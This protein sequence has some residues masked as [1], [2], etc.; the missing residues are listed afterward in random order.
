MQRFR[1]YRDNL[2]I[3]SYQFAHLF[4]HDT[5]LA[6]ELHVGLSL[7]PQLLLIRVLDVED[8]AVGIFLNLFF[9]FIV[10]TVLLPGLIMQLQTH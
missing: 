4:A 10:L 2:Q 6:L 5:S 7:L 9:G 3:K 8:L 1:D